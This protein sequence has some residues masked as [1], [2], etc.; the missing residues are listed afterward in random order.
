M[1]QRNLNPACARS[2]RAHISES[3]GSVTESASP[4]REAQQRHV[5]T[6]LCV[7]AGWAE[8]VLVVNMSWPV[9]C[10]YYFLL[11]HATLFHLYDPHP[12]PPSFSAFRAIHQQ[13]LLDVDSLRVTGARRTVM[14]SVDGLSKMSIASIL[15][16]S[17]PKSA[18]VVGRRES[19]IAL[20]G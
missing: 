11:E 10:W 2:K 7:I 6:R 18:T 9:A 16:S 12:V 13:P 1:R 8:V 15:S 4:N 20:F 14:H 5:N 17:H 19:R 3:F